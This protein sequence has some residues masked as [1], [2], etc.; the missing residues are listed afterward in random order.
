MSYRYKILS[1]HINMIIVNVVYKLYYVIHA[2]HLLGNELLL[3]PQDNW[4]TKNKN[5]NDRLQQ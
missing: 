1:L 4:R 2:S 3:T 5:L